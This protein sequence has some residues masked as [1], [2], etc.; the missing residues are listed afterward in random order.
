MAITQLKDGR[1]I[2][3]HRVKGKG[4]KNRIKKEYFSRGAGARAAAIRRNGADVAP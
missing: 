1:R 3:Y 4:G 2:C